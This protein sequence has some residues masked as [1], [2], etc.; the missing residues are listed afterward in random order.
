MRRTSNN[1]SSEY[2]TL[3]GAGCMFLSVTVGTVLAVALIASYT[4]IKI[5][6]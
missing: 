2:K 1:D 6:G 3:V 5:W 4:A